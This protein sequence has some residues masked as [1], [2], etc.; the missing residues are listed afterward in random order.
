MCSLE[1]MKSTRI[2][3]AHPRILCSLASFCVNTT[4]ESFTI[5]YLFN[6]KCYLLR[7]LLYFTKQMNNQKACSVRTDSVDPTTGI[8]LEGAAPRS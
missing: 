7:E 1:P 2:C 4:Q 6:F 5:I 3:A 8:L